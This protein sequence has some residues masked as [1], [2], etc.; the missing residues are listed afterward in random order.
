MDASDGRYGYRAWDVR[1]GDNV[2]P[3]LLLDPAQ[4][5]AEIAAQS[6]PPVPAGYQPRLTGMVRDQP[7]IEDVLGLAPVGG[8]LIQDKDEGGESTLRPATG[9]W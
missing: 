7:R 9:A 6:P 5:V 4:V 2:D 3:S 8:L 1:P